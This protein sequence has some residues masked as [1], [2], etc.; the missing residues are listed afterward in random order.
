MKK[1][2]KNENPNQESLKKI[3]KTE[4]IATSE[5]FGSH[6][7]IRPGLS[8]Y[9]DGETYE[10][11]VEFDGKFAYGNDFNTNKYHSG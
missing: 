3:A 8:D 1:T 4:S 11:I 7:G 2:N 6:S 5:H 10:E 9:N